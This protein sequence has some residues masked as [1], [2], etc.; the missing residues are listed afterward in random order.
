MHPF[1]G[2]YRD[3]NLFTWPIEVSECSPEGVGKLNLMTSL[4]SKARALY[5]ALHRELTLQVITPRWHYL[6][7]NNLVTTGSSSRVVNTSK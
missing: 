1:R 5:R 6:A 4:Q 2:K 7:D 3:F